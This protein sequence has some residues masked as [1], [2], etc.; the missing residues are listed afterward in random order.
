MAANSNPHDNTYNSTTFSGPVKAGSR[1]QPVPSYDRET[2]PGTVAVT[3]LPNSGYA[4]CSQSAAVM[5]GTGGSI[6]VTD[7]KIPAGSMLLAIQVIVTTPYD[8][9]DDKELLIGAYTDAPAHGMTTLGSWLKVGAVGVYSYFDNS[10]WTSTGVGTYPLR[11]KDI[12]YMY[13]TPTDATRSR[14]IDIATHA[15]STGPG[16]GIL[17]FSYI[18]GLHLLT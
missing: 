5:Q 4:I 10:N 13:E 14:S 2:V 11:W 9:V 18:P 12:S 3:A 17:T 1:R 8:A 16:R 6:N 15:N 7:I